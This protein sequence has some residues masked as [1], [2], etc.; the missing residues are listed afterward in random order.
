[1]WL[2][3][4]CVFYLLPTRSP[5]RS[6][7]SC[8]AMT[9]AWAPRMNRCYW[10]M[11]VSRMGGCHPCFPG[12]RFCPDCSLTHDTTPAPGHV[13]RNIQYW[14]VNN[15]EYYRG[16][17]HLVYLQQQVSPGSFAQR[18][19]VNPAVVKA[20]FFLNRLRQH[21]KSCVWVKETPWDTRMTFSLLLQRHH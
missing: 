17:F 1:M 20:V 9:A 13:R 2:I 8:W 12:E 14:Y 6:G 21:V 4:C 7:R 5:S 19:V 16:F 15:A 3:T 18:L 10:P 11:T